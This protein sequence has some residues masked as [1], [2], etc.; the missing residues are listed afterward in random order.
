MF[1]NNTFNAINFQNPQMS[2]QLDGRSVDLGSNREQELMTIL[3]SIEKSYDS[4]SSA[5][6][7]SHV[8]YNIVDGGFDRPPNFPLQL[9]NQALLPDKTLMPVILNRM[10]IEERKGM[11]NDLI[12]KLNGSKLVIFKKVESLKTK[13]EMLRNKVSVVI[14]KYRN[15]S[16]QFVE[17]EPNN[18]VYKLS[19]EVLNRSKYSVMKR[20]ELLKCLLEMKDKLVELDENVNELQA[21]H[22][23]KSISDYLLNRM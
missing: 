14:Q 9:W 11:Q 15:V 12:K 20:P 5:Y 21:I 1:G 13:R 17:G 18:D 23:Q 6:K 22:G 16:K 8:F 2:T 4:T 10:Q 19:V 3:D 7:F